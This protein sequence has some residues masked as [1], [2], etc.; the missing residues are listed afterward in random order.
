MIDL[1]LVH[2]YTFE[3]SY[4]ERLSPNFPKYLEVGTHCNAIVGA[5]DVFLI[6]AW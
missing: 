4:Q 1:D 5:P 3:I 2:I 6:V